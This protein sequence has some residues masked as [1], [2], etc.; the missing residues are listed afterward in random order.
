M[1]PSCEMIDESGR[2]AAQTLDKFYAQFG[3][4]VYLGIG[5]R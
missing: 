3:E 2:S 4:T 1:I 5:N